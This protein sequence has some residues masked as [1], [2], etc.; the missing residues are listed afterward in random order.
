MRKAYTYIAGIILLFAVGCKDLETLND[1][2]PDRE[3]VLSSGADLISVLE[4]GYVTW[5]Q[6][7]HGEHPAI[8]LSVSADAY[9]M[10]WGNF[11]AQRMGE[12]PRATYNN[13]A[14]EEADYRQVVEAPWYGC[15]SAVS[16]ANDVLAAL[17]RGVSVDNGGP[18]DEAIRAAAHFLRGVSWGYMGLL[19][20]KAILADFDADLSVQL[21]YSNYQEVIDAAVAELESAI[22]IADV[23]G[24]N[25][26]HNYFNG[27]I[28]GDQQFIQLCHAY[29]A[30]FL[31]R[32]CNV[33][34]LRW[35]SATTPKVAMM[36]MMNAATT[37][38]RQTPRRYAARCRRISASGMFLA[39]HSA[40]NTCA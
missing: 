2:N 32:S 34:R 40:S 5:W 18:Q 27:L 6:S 25:F 23:V 7:T 12:E 28:Y 11:G 33:A 37:L 9:G 36:A 14:T 39:T 26:V 13:R 24:D 10:S 35:R 38:A 15:L 8:A 29:S 17:D 16:S 31:A 30:R 4:G 20:D 1:N 21:P 22:E 19:F 3:L